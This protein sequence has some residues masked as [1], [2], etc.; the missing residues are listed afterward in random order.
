[1]NYVR[2][3]TDGWSIGNV[4]LNFIGGVSGLVQISLN[5]YNYRKWI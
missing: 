5:A 3:S 1:M 2:K 4:L